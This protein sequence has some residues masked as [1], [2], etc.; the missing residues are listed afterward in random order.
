M[1]HETGCRRFRTTS[2]Q[3][4]HRIHAFCPDP[5]S[6]CSGRRPSFQLD[7][8]PPQRRRWLDIRLEYRLCALAQDIR[9]TSTSRSLVARQTRDSTEHHRRPLPV[10]CNDNQ[11][12]PA[13]CGS[14]GR[15]LQLVCVN[16]RFLS[17]CRRVSDESNPQGNCHVCVGDRHRSLELLHHWEED[18]RGA[19]RH[20]Y[21]RRI[22]GKDVLCTYFAGSN[23]S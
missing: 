17:L 8:G 19:C 15:E 13:L 9:R 21:Q 2:A 22:E 3:R 20:H 14:H 10:F 4:H 12:L 16:A 11:F 7:R 18:L 23:Q 1:V 6:T 5:R